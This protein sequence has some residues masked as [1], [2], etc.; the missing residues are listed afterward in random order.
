MFTYD[1][2]SADATLVLVAKVRFE[3][4]D[5]VLNKG[6]RPDDSNFSDEEIEYKLTE[7]GNA[8]AATAAALC[9]VLAT[10]WAKEATT[11]TGDIQE[12]LTD[13]S[14]QYAERAK[15]LRKHSG[16]VSAGWNRKDGYNADTTSYT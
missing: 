2:A 5:T 11:K 13:I 12:N 14:K 6:P 7:Y 10:A 1:L 16:V 8:V 3:I 9:D 4:G 15:S